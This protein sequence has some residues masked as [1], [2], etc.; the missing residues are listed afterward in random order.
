MR[1]Y[2]KTTEAIYEAIR[3]AMDTESGFPNNVATTWFAPAA[4]APRD[5]E[6]NCLISAKPP[7]ADSFLQAGATE[8]S[9]A[10]YL[11]FLPSEDVEE[12]V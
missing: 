8:L 9:E 6:G 1:K 12:T 10:E 2:F 4:T 5:P 11:S 7:I 3:S